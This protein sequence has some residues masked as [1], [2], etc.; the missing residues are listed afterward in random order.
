MKIRI[1]KGVTLNLK[2]STICDKEQDEIENNFM[3]FASKQKDGLTEE[4]HCGLVDKFVSQEFLSKKKADESTFNLKTRK[5]EILDQYA[6]LYDKPAK[7][8]NKEFLTCNKCGYKQYDD[9]TCKQFQFVDYYWCGAC[10]DT[11]DDDEY[12][13]MQ[14]MMQRGGV[15]C[16]QQD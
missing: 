5:F 10:Q 1:R 14:I 12:A 13:L 7:I 2:K 8:M 15:K 4:N 6:I 16:T 9:D 3:A 11:A